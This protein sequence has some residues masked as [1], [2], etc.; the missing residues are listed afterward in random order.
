MSGFFEVPARSPGDDIDFWALF[1]SIWR[2][3]L[4]ICSIV[5]FTGAGAAAYALL[6]TPVYQASSILRP[7]A[8]NELDAL[9][10]SEIYSLPPATA[11]AK[12]TASLSSYEMR[13]SFFRKNQELFAQYIVPSR[14]LEQNFDEFNRNAIALDIPEPS[15]DSGDFGRSAI[16]TL[17][18]PKGVD[19]AL[20][21][22]K[23]V[24]YVISE[25]RE[26]ISADMSVLVRNRLSEID[27][28]INSA[29]ASY[30]LDKEAKIA[31]LTE[32]DNLKRAKLQDE[33]GALRLQ[34]K[35]L[36]ADRVALL[37]EALTVARSLGIKRPTTQSSIAVE[38]VPQGANVIKTE[39]NN[40]QT[41]LY[42]MGSDALE[43]ELG[44]LRTR[45]S[46]DF[47]TARISEIAKELQL[48]QV[49]REVEVLKKR[50]NDDLFLDNVQPLRAEAARLRGL[51]TD[52]SSVQ[53][54]SIDQRALPSEK[55]VKPRRA[56][57]VLAGLLVGLGL[58]FLV[59]FSRY[60]L[61]S[62]RDRSLRLSK[63]HVL[64]AQDPALRQ[65]GTI[66]IE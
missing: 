64:E 43:A 34:L 26:R 15:K 14:S 16:L 54:V 18:Y 59:A 2:Q 1:Q 28:K 44:T 3:K 23:F 52:L 40:Q 22:N 21:L 30:Q 6:S 39:V 55:P 20:I 51:S 31:S 24:D 9:N 27:G 42:F 11:L 65:A 57:I 36:R 66:R 37:N 56:F 60:Y 10:R 4:L 49:N 41:P 33:L 5:L 45:K 13:L 63:T 48:L 62:M 47:V 50:L 8:I 17:D 32:A 46:D 58:G 19:G 61:Q 35:L 25:E 12:V 7:A 53:L 29:R 38:N